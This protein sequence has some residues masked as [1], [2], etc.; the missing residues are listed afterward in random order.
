V[1]LH[2]IGGNRIVAAAREGAA[3]GVAL[4]LRCSVLDGDPTGRGDVCGDLHRA[5]DG[6]APELHA[7]AVVVQR[8]GAVDVTARA[9]SPRSVA[10]VTDE[11]EPRAGGDRDGAADRRAVAEGEGGGAVGGDGPIDRRVDDRE[12]RTRV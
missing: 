11:D 3:D 5:A 2:V 12:G 8:H 7:A 4:D 10:A 1:R 6:V 9:G